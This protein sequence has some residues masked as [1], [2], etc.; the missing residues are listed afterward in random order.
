MRRR[1]EFRFL[2]RG[3]RRAPPPASR[4]GDTVAAISRSR[5]LRDR[6]FQGAI[7]R[8][9]SLRDRVSGWREA[10]SGRPRSGARGYRGALAFF[11]LFLVFA[12]L[13]GPYAHAVNKIVRVSADDD[14]IDLATAVE[15]P[16]GEGDR[17]PVPTAPGPD[18]IV[19][20]MEVSALEAGSHPNWM[21]F[22]LTNDTD[23]QLTRLLVAPH[24]RFV[25]SG[26]IWPDLGS[27]RIATITASQG[28]PPEREDVAE[29]DA[30]RLTIDPGTTVTY[31]AE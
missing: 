7:S 15:Y 31:V 24:F 6:L 30:F 3:D 22:A 20:R 13:L 21:V 29:A 27:A 11:A 2:G 8:S 16:K 18:G 23:E 28:N 14:A 5:S 12:L 1:V 26:V 17:I 19:R 10:I 9:R 4:S 25:G